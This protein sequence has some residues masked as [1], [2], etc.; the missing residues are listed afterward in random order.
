MEKG[1]LEAFSDG[2]IAIIITIMVLELKLPDGADIKSL[3]PL[4]PVFISYILSFVYVGIYWNNHHH[5]FQ[6]VESVNGSILW[7]NMHLLFWLSLVPF[8]TWWMGKNDFARWPVT[9]Y[10]IVL[11]MNA[12]AYGIL[13]FALIR[14][15]GKNSLLAKAIGKDWKGNISIL[16]YAIAIGLSWVNSTISFI[17]YIVVA[18]VWFIPDRRIER[19]IVVEEPGCEGKSH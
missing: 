19:K 7:A 6:A 5:T 16:I 11:I 17:L 18:C 15:H 10:G 8:V 4:I 14:H 12:I 1:R 9:C 2:V 13:M 3:V